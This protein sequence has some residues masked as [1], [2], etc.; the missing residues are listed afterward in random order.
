MYKRS[1]AGLPDGF[2]NEHDSLAHEI[3]ADVKFVRDLARLRTEDVPAVRVEGG[4]ATKPAVRLTGFTWVQ[5][6]T[7]RLITLPRY[8]S[9]ALVGLCLCRYSLHNVTSDVTN[10]SLRLT[11]LRSA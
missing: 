7:R 9:I 1:R 10:D 4:H 8:C 5:I 11:S 6:M 2:V 3:V